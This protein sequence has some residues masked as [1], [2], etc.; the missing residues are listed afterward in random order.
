M[1]STSSRPYLRALLVMVCVVVLLHTAIAGQQSGIGLTIQVQDGSGSQNVILKEAPKPIIVRV[2]DRTGRPI[3]D[4]TVLFAAPESGPGG[5]FA[6]ESNPV[7]VF[8]DPQG[9]A[10]APQYR[11]NSAEGTYRIQVQASYMG[12]STTLPI[13][14]TNVSQ[15]KGSKKLIILTAV[16]GGAAAAALGAM[17]GGSGSSSSTPPSSPGSST[18]PSI[19]VGPSDV[20]PPQ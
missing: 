18:P 10:V 4:A 16:A 3:P 9:L 8:T 1:N 14:Q 19:T 11:A 17:K 5:N 13:V 12:E 15:K 6:T 2:M 7:I 20:G